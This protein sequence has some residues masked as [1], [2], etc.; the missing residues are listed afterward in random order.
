MT[1]H[2]FLGLTRLIK[3]SPMG[4]QVFLHLHLPAFFFITDTIGVVN[5][6][7]CVHFVVY[8]TE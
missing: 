8:N 2:Q 3:T 7:R 5:K 6:G 4:A 1:L